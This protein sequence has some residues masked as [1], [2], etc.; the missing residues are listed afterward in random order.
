MSN[1]ALAQAGAA[2]NQIGHFGIRRVFGSM[3]AP[4]SVTKSA[5]GLMPGVAGCA[6]A[7]FAVPAL[8]GQAVPPTLNLCGPGPGASGL[9]LV[10]PEARPWRFDDAVY[11]LLDDPGVQAFIGTAAY[12]AHKETRFPAAD[13]KVIAENPAFS[14]PDEAIRVRFAQAYA[15]TAALY[16]RGQPSLDAILGRI[17]E[18]VARL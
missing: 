2:P 10:G 3:P 1:L 13:N 17:G 9:D 16:Y 6:A 14:L 18:F 11:C 7:I 8:R 12:V 4:I 15:A 5:T